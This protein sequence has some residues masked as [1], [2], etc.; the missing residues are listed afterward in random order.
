MSQI[1]PVLLA[2]GAGTRLW[3]LS[4]KAYPKQFSNLL[5][6]QTLFQQAALRLTSSNKIKFASHIT[7]TNPDF[8]F[9]VT[10]QLQSVGIDPGHVIIEPEAKNTAPAILAASLHA[11]NLDED[12]VLLVAPSDHII[13]DTSEFHNVLKTGLASLD[14]GK[15]VTFGISPT[16]PDTGYG[17]IELSSK[18]KGPSGVSDVSKFVEKPQRS[19]AEEMLQTE[20]FL[21]NAGIFLFRAIDMIEA[22]KSFSPSIY[23]HTKDA[24]KL[25]QTDLGFIRLNSDAWSRL[26][27][28]S[29]D[30]AI[31]EKAKNLVAVPCSFDWSDLGG[32]DKVWAE[33]DKDEHGNSFTGGAHAIDCSDTLLRSE[34]KSQQL[35]GLGL[36]NIIAIAMQDAVLVT[37]KDNS[38]DVKKIVDHLK[39]HTISQA[40]F[41]QKDFRPWGWFESLISGNGFQV[42]QIYVKPGASLSL[43][44][45]K[46][47]SEH[48]I[49]VEGVAKVTID[50]EV[51]LVNQGH[52]VYVPLGAIHRVENLEKIPMTL[53]EVQIG[54][55]LGEDDIVRYEDK[56][57]R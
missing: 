4:R 53:I 27:D 57:N 30:Y 12:A 50:Q 37:N 7:L 26:E 6:E 23:K 9:I 29:I 40:E 39:L 54:S 38:Q 21:W 41:F 18:N 5:N 49:I 35:V 2:G 55:Y 17:Y 16:Y 19:I 48:W 45:H 42:K 14:D 15:M 52:S 24:V 44:S 28:I 34:S 1:Y 11:Y 46:Y 20:N 32:W 31:M 3:P 33:A 51:K 22:F 25:A 36:N 47:R 8:R 43:Q 13:P 56:Y 10:E